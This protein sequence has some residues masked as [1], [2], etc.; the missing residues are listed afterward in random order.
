M[1]N[2]LRQSGQDIDSRLLRQVSTYL[3]ACQNVFQI[4]RFTSVEYELVWLWRDDE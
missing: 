1:K 4:F 3:E 2:W